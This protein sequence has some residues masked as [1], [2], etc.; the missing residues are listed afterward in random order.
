MPKNLDAVALQHLKTQ[1][2]EGKTLK[3]LARDLGVSAP[4]VSKLLR[5]VGASIRSKGRRK[6]IRTGAMNEF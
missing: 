2:E 1:Y 4:T 5:S 3:V 6:K